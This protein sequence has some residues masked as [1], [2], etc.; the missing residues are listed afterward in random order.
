MS[1]FLELI[2][3]VRVGEGF[4]K[5]RFFTQKGVSTRIFSDLGKR[6]WVAQS[7]WL[8]SQIATTA[9]GQLGSG[10]PSCILYLFSV[11][12]ARP[13]WMS[14]NIQPNQTMLQFYWEHNY[15]EW[16][17]TSYWIILQLLLHTETTG[18]LVESA[19][20]LVGCNQKNLVASTRP[21]RSQSEKIGIFWSYQSCPLSIVTRIRPELS[22]AICYP[23]VIRSLCGNFD[24]CL[25]Y[26]A[27]G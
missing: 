9:Y 14:A 26:H 3:Y 25:S 2:E 15:V 22:S 8:G 18:V 6:R 11:M 10:Q 23:N 4:K 21:T 16:A 17:P 13:N 12:R 7:H 19:G 27:N 24:I 5:I 1:S 20:V